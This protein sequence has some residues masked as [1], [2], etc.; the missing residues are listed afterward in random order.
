MS[1]FAIDPVE[2]S[3]ALI[4]RPSVT[5]VDAGA[6]DVLIDVLTPLG[7][8][9]FDLT[10]DDPAGE[11]TRNLY[12]RLGNSGRNF[13]FA[14][15]T[16]VVPPGNPEDWSSDPF[17]P[18]ERGGRLYGRGAADMKCAIAA[19]A[20]ATAEFLRHQGADFG[21]SI[22]FLITGDEE[23]D[24]T[25]GTKKV[26]DWLAA[27]DEKIDACVVGEPTNPDQLGEMVKIGRRGSMNAWIT[28]DGVQGHS[29]YPHLADNP[30]H[31]LI[32]LLSALTS[33]PL[34][35]GSAHFQPSVLQVTTVDVGNAATNVIPAKAEARVNIRFNDL[36]TSA[37]I[38]K[39]LRG[40]MDQAGGGYQMRTR[41]SGE[42]FLTP[43]GE[44][45]AVAAAAIADQIGRQPEF[46]T[47][48]GTSDARFIKDHCPVVEFGLTNATAHKIDENSRTDDIRALAGIYA[49][50]LERYFGKPA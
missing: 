33:V 37:G 45:S 8:E 50:M 14:G 7:F 42:S 13:C 34:D 3:K 2:L 18:E 30:I 10:F 26:L 49:R 40:R 35:E 17:A 27:R 21:D 36:H 9:I 22:S 38:E 6:L 12:A 46:S 31:K 29:A 1:S 19:M 5:P 4:R 23:G 25:N 44:L 39:L 15:H 20:A 48:G 47:T 16:D 43:P 41:V 28:V 32:A 11:P 24:A